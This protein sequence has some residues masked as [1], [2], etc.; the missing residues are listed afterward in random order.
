MEQNK[1]DDLFY[2]YANE[3][4]TKWDGGSPVLTLGKFRELMNDN[5]FRVEPPVMRQLPDIE[6]KI[7]EIIKQTEKFK[8]YWGV[9]YATELNKT[10]ESSLN[11]IVI[12]PN[13]TAQLIANYIRQ[14]SA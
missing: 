14:L 4:V 12:D 7:L 11:D 1:I 13:F 10:S 6:S 5:S 9:D 2:K 8:I 3:K